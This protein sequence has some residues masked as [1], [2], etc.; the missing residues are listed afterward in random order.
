MIPLARLFP[1]EG[2]M[3]QRSEK[4]RLDVNFERF[5]NPATK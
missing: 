3:V 2:A 1:D 4:F 5:I